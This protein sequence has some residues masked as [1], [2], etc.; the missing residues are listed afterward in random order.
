M[1]RTPLPVG[2]EELTPQGYTRVKTA[3]GVWRLK[4]HLIAEENLG[5][6]ID[7]RVERVT[8]KD[9]DRTNLNSENIMVVPKRNS[10]EKRIEYLKTQIKVLSKE[11][12]ELLAHE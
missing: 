4:H 6:P 8:F 1:S 10:R 2:H 9:G 11:L 7:T 12:E 5:R 3:L